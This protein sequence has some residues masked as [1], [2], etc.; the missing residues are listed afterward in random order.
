MRVCAAQGNFAQVDYNGPYCQMLWPICEGLRNLVPRAGVLCSS[1]SG[2]Q[3]LRL[4]DISLRCDP[5]GNNIHPFIEL[6]HGQALLPAFYVAPADEEGVRLVSLHTGERI[7][8]H[9]NCGY[10]AHITLKIGGGLAAIAPGQAQS[11]VPGGVFRPL[12]KRTA[13]LR[14]YKCDCLGHDGHG[15]WTL[16]GNLAAGT[17]A[18]ITHAVGQPYNHSCVCGNPSWARWH[19]GWDPVAGL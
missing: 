9:E 12:H 15:A 1:E 6:A 11:Y 13:K 2:I 19:H 8:K 7:G 10:E 3:I 4:A 16:P 14:M 18:V 17:G 5:L